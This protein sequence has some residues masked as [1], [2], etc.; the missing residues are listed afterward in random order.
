M[1][2]HAEKKASS[3]LIDLSSRLLCQAMQELLNKEPDAF[4]AVTVDNLSAVKDFIP[5][6]ILVDANTLAQNPLARWPDAKLILIDT[7]LNKEDVIALLL[8]YKLYGIIST[9]T[10]LQLFRKA[11]KAIQNGQ[12]WIDNSK[13]KAVIH[14]QSLQNKSLG[15][16]TLSKK[17]R[18]IVQLVA[19][20]HKNKEIAGKLGISEQ[21][22]KAHLSRIFRK[23]N[24]TCR[25][26]LVPLALTF[27]PTLVQ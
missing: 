20:G 12:V 9:E 7:G 21:T 18:E 2:I 22:V 1:K 13:L 6:K 24:V 27:K 17:E 11:L 4:Q 15:H 19:G 25:S 10:D 23:V 16:E 26:Q 8:S 5:D 3:I 14:G